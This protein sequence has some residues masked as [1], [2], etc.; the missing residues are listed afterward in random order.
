MREP[1]SKRKSTEGIEFLLQYNL[2]ISTGDSETKDHDTKLKEAR[3][4]NLDNLKR[5]KNKEKLVKLDDTTSG[6][7]GHSSRSSGYGSGTTSMLDIQP[8]QPN[9]KLAMPDSKLHRAH[10]VHGRGSPSQ[11]AQT[12]KRQPFKRRISD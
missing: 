2:S 3:Q 5:L 8:L 10:T 9:L 1:A 11:L 7:S 4:I 12:K 6:F